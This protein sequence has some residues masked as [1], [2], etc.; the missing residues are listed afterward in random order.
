ML[1][2]VAYVV[3]G[4]VIGWWFSRGAG[5]PAMAVV[6][7]LVGG[8]VGGYA[9]QYGVHGHPTIV[10]YGSIIVSIILALIL[11]VAGRGRSKA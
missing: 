4:L 10:K 11:A 1:H 7:G 9:V 2:L 6:L 5:K 8:L 3:I